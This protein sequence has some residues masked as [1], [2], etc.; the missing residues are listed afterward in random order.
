MMTVPDGGSRMP[1]MIVVRDC[2]FRWLFMM[3]VPKWWFQ[4]VVPD[5][6]GGVVLEWNS[7]DVSS[8]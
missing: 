6:G 4:M 2:C 1:V 7:S 8:G 3:T 5:E